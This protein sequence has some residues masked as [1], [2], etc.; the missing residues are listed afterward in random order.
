MDFV[1][2]QVKG[3]FHGNRNFITPV[4]LTVFVWVLL[5]FA[6]GAYG[7]RMHYKAIGAP[8][9][10][11]GSGVSPRQSSASVPGS[12]WATVRPSYPVRS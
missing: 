8:A 3:I 2:E 7:L 9:G 11:A 5:Y 4:A 6:A 1:D 10:G 12:R